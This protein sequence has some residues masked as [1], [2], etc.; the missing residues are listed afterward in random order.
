MLWLSVP[1]APVLERLIR[2]EVM[3]ERSFDRTLGQLDRLQR[4]RLGHP[5]PPPVKLEVSRN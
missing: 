1:S 2:Y 5:V 4:M 3:L